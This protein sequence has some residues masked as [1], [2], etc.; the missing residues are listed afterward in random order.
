[1]VCACG[2]G[3][4]S[5][6]SEGREEDGQ[7]L[8]IIHEPTRSNRIWHENA[9]VM[10]AGLT[11]PYV[12]VISRDNVGHCKKIFSAPFPVHDHRR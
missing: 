6:G 8:E 4:T 10:D 7:A 5:T 1:M 2:W 9:E 11:S 12:E 3:P